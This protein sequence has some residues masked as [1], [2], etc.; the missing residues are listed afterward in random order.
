MLN[1]AQTNRKNVWKY[2]LI[3]PVLVGF[4]L[5]FQIETVAQER[6]SKRKLEK[7]QKLERLN[8]KS[9]VLEQNLELKDIDSIMKI[10]DG[11][12]ALAELEIE[13]SNN[14]IEKSKAELDKV[15]IEI[16]KAELELQKAEAQNEKRLIIINGKEYRGSEFKGN[17]I[18]DGKLTH[19]DNNDA[20]EKFGE[21]G[22]YGAII[23]DGDVKYDTRNEININN[24]KSKSFELSNGDVCLLL[25]GRMLKIPGYPTFDFQNKNNQLYIDG[26]KIES[27]EE[28]YNYNHKLL[29][30]VNIERESGKY[31]IYFFTK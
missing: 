1:K 12:I 6:K 5:L 15:E 24:D 13:K 21:K 14:E 11:E 7:T 16:E 10:R 20:V 18:V 19:Y 4:I 26:K 28:F 31:I 22:K 29:K 30:T 17:I 3:L 25:K 27:F 9:I 2:G 23:I 8:N